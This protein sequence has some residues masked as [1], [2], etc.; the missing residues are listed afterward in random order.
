MG[1]MGDSLADPLYDLN[2]NNYIYIYTIKK[3][4]RENLVICQQSF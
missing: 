1:D 4:N 3:Q 2:E